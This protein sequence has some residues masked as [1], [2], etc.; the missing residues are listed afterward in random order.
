MKRSE[1]RNLV[2]ALGGPSV[3]GRA[4]GE[5][6]SHSAVSHWLR[7]P[8]EHC[9]TIEALAREKQVVRSDGTPYVCELFRP[10]VR[11]SELR[12]NQPLAPSLDEAA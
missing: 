4:C 7:I 10:E 3:V 2:K 11:W 1:L 9:P 12:N 8:V 5:G 6:I